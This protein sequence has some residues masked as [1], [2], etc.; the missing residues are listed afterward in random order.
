[1]WLGQQQ[2]Q[3]NSSGGTQPL[4]LQ[5][6]QQGSSRPTAAAAGLE[7]VTWTEVTPLAVPLPVVQD[8]LVMPVRDFE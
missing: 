8:E 1:V 4:L 7:G 6:H 5:Q 3:G 2:Q